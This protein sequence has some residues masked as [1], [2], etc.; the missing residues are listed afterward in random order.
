MYNKLENWCGMIFDDV[1]MLSVVI[2]A[3]NEEKCIY[4][5]LFETVKIISA[6]KTDFE[7]VCV[8]DGSSDKTLELIK[9]AHEKDERIRW[10]TYEENHGKGYAIKTGV[11]AANGEYI[12][13]LDADLELNPKQLEGF[14]RKM[15]TSNADVV[16]GCKLHKASQIKY[17]IKRKIMSIGYYIMLLLLFR[18]NV[19]DTQTGLKLFKAEVIKPIMPLLKTSG[20][21]YDIE[22]LAAANKR[23]YKIAEMPVRVV[24]VREKGSR[25]ITMKDVWKAFCDTW[26]IFYRLNFQKYYS[27]KRV[28]R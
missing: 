2:P 25:R 20:F 3:Y 27:E 19:K 9:A 8:N 23:G 18:L 15:F 12:A 7:L 11:E 22:I 4:D 6:F 1:G 24:Y 21:A 16:I 10:V 17:P 26:A 14:M 5:N 13:F 28:S